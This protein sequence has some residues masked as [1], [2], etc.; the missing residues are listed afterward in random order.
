VPQF[1]SSVPLACHYGRHPRDTRGLSRPPNAQRNTHM[2]MRSSSSQA[3]SARV[4]FSSPA[5]HT[6]ALQHKQ[7]GFSQVE[8]RPSA[9]QI[10]QRPLA[11]RHDS[12]AAILNCRDP[13]VDE[14]KLSPALHRARYRA[15]R[16]NRALMDAL[17]GCKLLR[18][19]RLAWHPA[20]DPSNL[21]VGPVHL[22]FDDCRGL[23]LAGRSDWDP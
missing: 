7:S 3:D 12:A 5:P 8:Q 2:R 11:R 13:R 23:L 20:S 4:R 18:V 17:I 9:L 15:L 19:I 1:P 22:V 16:E 21:N 6:K 14:S 10:G